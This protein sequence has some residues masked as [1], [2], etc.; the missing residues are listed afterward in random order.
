[1]KHRKI[2]I[3]RY[4]FTLRDVKTGEVIVKK[5]ENIV[6][7]VGLELITNNLT[8]ATPTNSMLISHAALGDDD[9]AVAEGDTIL[10]NETY[11]NAVASRTNAG[12]TAYATAF[13]GQAE[14]TG[15]FKEAGIFC[16]GTGSADTGILLSH[17]NVDITKNNTQTLTLDWELVFANAA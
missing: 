8:D 7:T 16:D 1:M 14:V 11:R 5:Y 17:V 2:L 6:P 10:G 15:T 3:G 12:G 13:Y 9:T 4:T